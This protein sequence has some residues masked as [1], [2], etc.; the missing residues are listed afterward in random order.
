VKANES[1][2]REDNR[3]SNNRVKSKL[4]NS[5][6]VERFFEKISIVSRNW[7]QQIIQ[8]PG[9]FGDGLKIC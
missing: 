9:E 4:I 6:L 8:A 7:V 1:D 3:A 2:R 5:E